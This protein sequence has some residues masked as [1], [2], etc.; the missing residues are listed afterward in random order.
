L[1]EEINKI[2]MKDKGFLGTSKM[3]N[4]YHRAITGEQISA[5]RKRQADRT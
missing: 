3:I 2:S 1:L 4:Y 5:S